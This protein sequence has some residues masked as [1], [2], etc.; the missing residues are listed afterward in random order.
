MR[1]FRLVNDDI[2]TPPWCLNPTIAGNTMVSADTNSYIPR[3]TFDNLN[4]IDY[5]SCHVDKSV[6]R[7]I[8]VTNNGDTPVKF[9]FHDSI[10]LSLVTNL[11]YAQQ[12][13]FN[14]MAHEIIKMTNSLAK[15]GSGINGNLFQNHVLSVKPKHGLFKKNE[16]Q[17]MTF[18]FS[19]LEQRVYEAHLS[20]YFNGSVN[21]YQELLLRGVG[22]LPQ[23]TF[24]EQNN[25]CFKPTCIGALSEK[26]FPIR[27]SSRIPVA[28]EVINQFIL[29]F[30]NLE[31]KVAYSKTICT[32][33]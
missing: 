15:P 9:T 23:I 31:F 6:Y 8:K 10:D 4:R 27:N 28:F 30:I 24:G 16:S 33:C 11:K 19:P 12:T 18:R 22:Y 26:V 17:L 14:M 29:L 21:N 3:I 7:V 2:F 25:L 20:C 5:P 1:N 32:I 13:G